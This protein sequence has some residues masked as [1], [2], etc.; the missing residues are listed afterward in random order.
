MDAHENE[1]K[2]LRQDVEWAL[3][4]A[5]DPGEV[6]PLLHRLTR[7]AA[8][9]SEESVYAHRQLAELLVERHPWRAALH[10]RKVLLWVKDDDRAWAVLGLC[11]TLLGNYK[12][13]AM[14]YFRALSASPK[15]PWYAHNL[16]HLIDVA[17]G[18]AEEAVVWLQTAYEGAVGNREIAASFAH[19]LARAGK[20]QEAKR[21]LSRAMKRGVSREQ[22]A[23]W[24][25]LEAGA[26]PDG[27]AASGAAASRI[28]FQ[29]PSRAPSRLPSPL[30]GQ[31]RQP[32]ELRLSGRPPQAG[33]L[34]LS[35][36]APQATELGPLD[37]IERA[38]ATRR[39]KPRKS[40]EESAAELDAS[41]VRGLENL[42]L[43]A[44]QRARALVIAR[45]PAVRKLAE[46]GPTV[47][48]LAAALAYTIVYLDHV[49]LTQAEVA[50]SFRVSAASL[51][52]R[53]SALRAA[54]RIAPGHA[55]HYQRH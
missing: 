19:A 11:Q 55:P 51:R 35:G 30:A 37:S 42:P 12:Y 13:A 54:L 41:L 49:P 52:G 17:L 6:L 15:N 24:R 40:A 9:A 26:P 23:L 20:L 16:G 43:D 48:G 22:A 29:L 53:F 5:L 8:P 18:R 46:D 7:T 33:D 50:A 38:P 2:R 36:R 27:D 10:A 31:S 1:A 39:R 21:V 32:T 47:Q 34:R 45:E 28:S 25:W 14:A 4:S 3:Q 44:R